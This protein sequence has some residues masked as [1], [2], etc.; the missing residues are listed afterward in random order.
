MIDSALGL[1]RNGLPPGLTEVAG[2]ASAG[3]TQLCL[4]L[5]IRAALAALLLSVP[6]GPLPPLPPAPAPVIF[7]NAEDRMPTAR[8]LQL[9]RAAVVELAATRGGNAAVTR[10][11][12][13]NVS[14]PN[15]SSLAESDVIVAAAECLLSHILIVEIS[16]AEDLDEVVARLPGIIAARGVRLVILDSV[17]AIFRAEALHLQGGASEGGGIAS[18]DVGSAGG[19]GGS[20]ISSSGFA[21]R[22]RR[23]GKLAAELKALQ[24]CADGNDSP[25]TCAIFVTN[26]V[27]DVV[28]DGSGFE[29]TSAAGSGASTGSGVASGIYAPA[30]SAPCVVETGGRWLKPALGPSWD[31][32]VTSRIVLTHSRMTSIMAEQRA[33]PPHPLLSQFLAS[34]AAAV[35]SADAATKDT[36]QYG[37]GDG[38]SSSGSDK[39]DVARCSLR[40][41]HLLLS[42][43]YPQRSCSF[44]ITRGGLRGVALL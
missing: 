2:E 15:S 10:L 27:S 3:K 5:A 20:G 4:C 36:S 7:I 29:I 31:A 8:L 33:L 40:E 16:D 30:H 25:T 24:T 38:P 22:A 41:A 28:S 34:E 43:A 37:L 14:L 26:Q 35:A 13:L 17:A 23:L 19:G 32:F 44:L 21:A 39:D 18:S 42:P 6:G 9:A 1:G 12:A 11:A